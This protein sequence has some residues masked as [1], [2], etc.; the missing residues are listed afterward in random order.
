MSILIEVRVINNGKK[1]G[2]AI[3]P[4]ANVTCGRIHK[5]METDRLSIG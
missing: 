1:L 4:Q 2:G 5:G 3:A